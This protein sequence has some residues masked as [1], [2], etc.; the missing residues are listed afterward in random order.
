MAGVAVL[1]LKHI[2]INKQL[3]VPIVI[4]SF[5]TTAKPNWASSDVYG[6][7][8]PI[9][10]Y[11]NTVRTFTAVLRT[12]RK[13]E[14]FTQKQYEVFTSPAGG[15]SDSAFSLPSGGKYTYIGGP[16]NY[17]RDIADL[18]KMMYPVYY[19][20]DVGNR[21]A[22]FLTA[23]PLLTLNL[24]GI[25]YDGLAGTS[26]GE[27]G[28]GLLF[29]PETFKVNSLVDTDKPS[30][31]VSSAEDLRF[32]ANAEGY[33][34]T[35]GGTIVHR[36]VRPGFFQHPGGPIV[37]T[38]GPNFPYSTDSKSRFSDAKSEQD[39]LSTLR[40]FESPP[41]DA[42]DIDELEERLHMPH[43]PSFGERC[44]EAIELHKDAEA[45]GIG[46]DQAELDM[47]DACSGRLTDL[48]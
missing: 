19:P 26:L 38:Q 31:T 2:G 34:I 44:V 42:R 14:K 3:T 25:A 37:F 46:V 30:I 16:E 5:E 22:S 39:R 21:A 4:T 17:M 40:R 11:Q 33:T 8:D 45:S 47:Q 29:V 48:E 7:M 1:K 13:N 36:H 24:S 43:S 10:T 6:R 9:F 12:P 32:F 15:K 41:L 27:V 35:L 18:Y 20:L 28:D 23:A